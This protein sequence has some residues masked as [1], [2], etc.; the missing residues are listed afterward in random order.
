MSF[1]MKR[2]RMRRRLLNLFALACLAFALYL[3]AFSK[4]ET[5]HKADNS[6]A[7]VSHITDKAQSPASH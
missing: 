5:I 3:I 1:S 2:R 6:T 7:H 4:E